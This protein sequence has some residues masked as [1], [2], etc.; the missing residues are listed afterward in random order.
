MSKV[1]IK[2]LDIPIIRSCNLNCAGCLTFSDNKKIKGLVNLDES[3]PWLEYWST[4]LDPTIVTI[5]GGEPLLHPQFV[6]WYKA[7][8]YYFPDSTPRINTNGYYLNTLFDKVEDFFTAEL[9]P[10]FIVSVQTEA[11]P[12]QSIVRNNIAELKSRVLEHWLK[13]YPDNGVEW[14]L[15]L[16]EPEWFKQWWAIFKDGQNSGVWITECSQFSQHWQ[17]HYDGDME[18]IR[19]FYKWTDPYA[20]DNHAN[21]QAAPFTN[22][23]KGKIYK[24]PT[25]AVLEHTLETY[26]IKD[27]PE[28]QDYLNNYKCLDMNSTDE[29][30]AAWFDTQKAPENICNMCGFTGPK[31]RG[32]GHRNGHE[33]KEGWK[34]KH[35]PIVPR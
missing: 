20:A 31:S 28:W 1:K 2:F 13:K 24:C 18:N 6:E 10:R 26:D 12:Y 30:I 34:L 7:V 22:L 29:E 17:D 15:W 11:E 14:K 35:I 3:I 32:G 19:P 33:P 16:D 9:Q 4:K 8:K 25:V 23:Y 21:C 5:F 27:A